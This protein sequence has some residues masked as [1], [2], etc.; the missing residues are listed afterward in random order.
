M[1]SVIGSRGEALALAGG[2]GPRQPVDQPDLAAVLRRHEGAI[3]PVDDACQHEACIARI[4]RGAIEQLKVIS[5]AD[6][7]GLVRKSGLVPGDIAVELAIER[8]ADRRH[9]R[10]GEQ[11]AAGQ[12]NIGRSLRQHD[13]P[14]RKPAAIEFAQRQR[15]GDRSA[16]LQRRAF[17]GAR[18]HDAAQQNEDDEKKSQTRPF[19]TNTASESLIPGNLRAAS[20]GQE[21]SLKDGAGTVS[22]HR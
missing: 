11:L 4:E 8:R 19:L 1:F 13:P 20:C 18:G 5:G 2:R 17:R 12:G 16:A 10:Q 21:N 22:Q 9:R 3:H 7:D 14:H 15:I 6:A